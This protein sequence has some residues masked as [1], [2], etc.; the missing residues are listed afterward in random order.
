LPGWSGSTVHIYDAAGLPSLNLSSGV[1]ANV[2]IALEGSTRGNLWSNNGL[3]LTFSRSGSSSPFRIRSNYT[4]S[5]FTIF[6]ISPTDNIP[7]WYNT[8]SYKLP[9]GTDAQRPVGQVGFIRHNTTTSQF[10][11]VR[12]GT[13]W[14]KILT[15]SVSYQY[16]P[17]STADTA[18]T[19]GDIS[20]DNSYIY[21]KT[22]SG[23]L[24]SSLSSF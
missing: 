10:E 5:A 14:E 2:G 24:R 19:A 22:S 13:T 17:T 23:W 4:G 8:S 6:Q 15:G 16:T 12:S 18:G 20:F 7:T 1:N 21:V 9:S 11:V 3:D